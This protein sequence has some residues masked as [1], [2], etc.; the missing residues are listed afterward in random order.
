MGAGVSTSANLCE[1][2]EDLTDLPVYPWRGWMPAVDVIEDQR[3][4]R[5]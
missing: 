3:E 5:A 2:I 4:P 1:R